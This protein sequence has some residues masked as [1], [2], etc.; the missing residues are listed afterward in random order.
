MSP[1]FIILSEPNLYQCD[2]KTEMNVLHAQY[3]CYLNSPDFHNDELPL[4]QRKSYGGTM[5]LWKLSLDPFIKCHDCPSP[6]IL[7]LVFS[8]PGVL[9]SI[10]I[11]L[12]LPTAGKND[13]YVLEIVKLMH[14]IDE[15]LSLHPEA[16]LFI[17]GDSNANL[18]DKLRSSMITN[19][20]DKW[21]LKRLPILHNT[22]HH[23][24]GN[25]A[26]DSELDI[27]LYSDNTEEH[28]IKIYCQK[29]DPLL[30]SHHDALWSCFLLPVANCER[31]Q[32]LPAA[33]RVPNLRAKIHWSPEG[34]K[35]YEEAVSQSLSRLRDNWLNVHSDSAISVLLQATNSILDSC[36]RATNPFTNLHNSCRPKAYKKPLVL[37]R[38]ENSLRRTHK[39]LKRLSPTSSKYSELN[40]EHKKRKQYHSRLLRHIAQDV[41]LT[42]DRKLNSILSQSPNQAYHLLKSYRQSGNKKVNKLNVG[43]LCFTGDSVPDGIYYSIEQLKTEPISLTY[44]DRDIPDFREE[45]RLILDI[46]SSGASIPALTRHKALSILSS[47]RSGVNDFFSITSQ[48]YLNAGES[49]IDHFHHLLNAII[50]NVNLSNITELNTIYACVL[51]KGTGKDKENSRSYRTISTCP[52]LAKALD[53][54]IR[55]LSL[56]GW[57][58]K[59]ARTQYQG[60][61]MSHEL[62]S[63]LLSETL[64]YSVN[65]AKKPVYALFLDAKS[66]FDRT[67]KE[68]LIR[69]LFFAGTDDQRLLYLN[70]RLG[71]RNTYCEFDKI[72]MGPIHDTRGLEQGGISSSDQYKIYNNE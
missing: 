24:M 19:L 7:P 55:E 35:L 49:G 70:N 12:Y 65:I 58:R 68:I 23:F 52:L 15:L 57:Q 22:Y 18:K 1:D 32:T 60:P 9:K 36:A 61:G 13:E 39:M 31:Q 63:L 71:N 64:Q 16:C 27:I 56:N 43:N 69:N 33:P 11:V 26:S 72:M 42:R 38:S 29:E 10:H 50:Q 48:H 8:P 62:A 51:L 30:T 17:R 2:L 3:Q 66:A 47:L 44:L 4:Y 53:C 21:N 54:Y 45:Y 20:C 34:L 5:A 40:E 25:G 67:T 14:C 37:I 59:Q 6:G 28:L 46:C 41:A